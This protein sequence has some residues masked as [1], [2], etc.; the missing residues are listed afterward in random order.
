MCSKVEAMTEDECGKVLGRGKLG[1]EGFGR[2][3][4]RVGVYLG[5]EV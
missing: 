2:V 1:G 3:V 4:E 5:V